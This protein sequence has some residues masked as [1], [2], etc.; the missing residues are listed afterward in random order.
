MA[1][2]LAVVLVTGLGLAYSSDR[3]LRAE[4][5]S[6]EETL[7]GNNAS[8]AQEEVAVREEEPV[9]KAAPEAIEEQVEET[10]D[11]EEESEEI[12]EASAEELADEDA[13]EESDSDDPAD[14]EEETWTVTFYNRDAEVHKTVKVAKGEAIG[15][16]L[17]AVI[18]REDYRAYWA[19]GEIV[20]G[21]QGKEI[22][23][24]G[25][26]INGNFKPSADTVIV[27]DYD[28]ISYSITFL[29]EKD[30]NVLTTKTVDYETSY[31]LNDIPAVPA[32]EGAVGKWAYAGGVFNNSVAVSGDTVVWAV[33]DKN[34]FTVTFEVNGK[35]YETDT[36]FDGD[37]LSLPADPVVE[38]K[39]FKGWFAG[40]KEYKGGETVS[41]DMTLTAEFTDQFHVNFTFQKEDGTEET[42]SQFF[43][44][45]GQTIETMP[46]D[47]FVSGKVFEKWVNVR[48]GEEVTAATVVNENIEARAQFRAVSVYDITV[49]YYYLN[50]GGQEVIFTREMMQAESHELPYTI[51]APATIQTDPNEVSGAPVYYP[52]NPTVTLK[53]SDFSGNKATVRIKFV[54]FTAVYDFVYLLKD[55]D[56]E[57]YTEID[58]TPNV[59]GVLNSYV[60]PAVKSFDYAVLERAE[61]ATIEQASGQE[62]NVYYT[63]RNFTL[64]YETNGG[65][66]VGGA[67]VPYGTEQA[68]SS[69]VPARTGY[70]FAGWYLDEGL[71]QPAGQKVTVNGNTTLYAKWTGNKVNYTIVYMAEKFNDNGTSTTYVYDNSKTATAQVGS[72]VSASNAPALSKARYEADAAKNAESSVEIAADGS[73][74]LYVYYKLKS[75]TIEFNLNNNSSSTTMK[76]GGTTYKG[77]SSTRYTITVKLGQSLNGLWP[78]TDNATFSRSGYSFAGWRTG[79]NSGTTYVTKQIIATEELLPTGS[80]SSR[81]FYANWSNKT[82]AY[83]INYYL[84]NADDNGYTLSAEYSQTLNAQN[85]ASFSAKEISGYNHVESKDEHKG[86]TF[87]FYY[88]RY[89][90]AIEYY[91]GSTE[92]KTISGVKFDAHITGS[93]YN[94]TPSAAQCG[95]DSDYRFDGWYSDSGLNSK[96]TFDTM[97]AS[98][99][100]LYAKWTAPAYTVSFVDGDD[101]SAKLAD[102]QTVEKYKKAEKPANPTKAGYSF[103]GWYKT[104]GGDELFDWNTQITGDT[105]V[106]AHW[107]RKNL[108]YTVHYVN[109]EGV[110]VA[111]DKEVTNPNFTVGQDVTEMAI[112]VAGFRP[113]ESSKILTLA[114]DGNEITFVYSAKADKT[115]YTVR[116]IIDPAEYSG[117]IKVAEDKVV[118]EVSGDTSS[119]IEMAAAVDYSALYAAHPELEGLEFHPDQVEKTLVLTPDAERNVLTFKYSSFKHAD[120]TIHYV[121]MAGKSISGDHK[122]MMKVGKTFTLSSTPIEG[123]ELNKAVVG[124]AYGGSEAASEYKITEAAADS[125]L[126]FTLFYQKKATITVAS[127][128][129]QYDGEALT[130]AE[131]L[132]HQ[133]KAEGLMDGHTLSAV[134]FTYANNDVEGGRLNAGIATVTPKDASISGAADNYYI[135][136]YISGTLE[137]TKINV[138]IRVEPDRWTGASYTGNVY[139][140]GF[141][142]PSKDVDD[143]VIIS[144]EGYEAEYLDDIWNAVKAK[145]TYDA[146]AAGLGYYGLAEKDA[147]DYTWNLTLTAADLPQNDNYS[148]SAHVRQGR[149]QILAKEVSVSTEG[150]TKGY[151]GTALTNPAGSISGL[152]QADEGKVTVTGTGSQTEVGESSNTYSIAWGDVN[153]KNYVIANESLGTLKVTEGSIILTASSASKTYDGKALTSSEVTASGLPEGYTV[154]ASASGSQTDAGTG[155]NKVGEAFKVKDA[156]GKDKTA[157]FTVSKRI[158]GTLTVNKAA[159]T[160]TT[161]SASKAYDGEALTNAE[162]KIEGLV[163]GETA[164]VTATGSQ[165]EIGS[166]SNTCSIEWG[167]AKADNYEV[168]QNLG[169]L[170]VTESSIQVILTASSAS[171]TYDG[172]ALT[173]SEVTASG[174]PEGFTVEAS[175]SGS[176]T[177]A[178]TSANVVSDGF[179]IRNAKGEDKTDNFKKVEKVAGTLTVNKAPLTVATGSGSK[180]YDGKA[181]KVAEAE[182]T[183]LVNGETATAAATGSRTEVG[184]GSNT[185]SIAWGTAKAGNY[186]VTENLGTLTVTANDSPVTLT[187]ASA[188][189]TY[190]GKALTDASVTA[191]GLPEGF[192]ADAKAA[193]SQ[194]N[195]G[196][197]ANVVKSGYAIKNAA[198]ENK[199]ANFTNIITAN[200]TLTVSKATLTVTTGS[201]N[202]AYDGRALTEASASIDGLVNNE[203]AK[204]TAKGSQTEVGSSDNGYEITW[205]FGTNKDNY[206]IKENLGTLTVTENSSEIVLTAASASKKYD[207]QALTDSKVKV[208]G[209]PSGFTAEAAAEGS[210]TNAGTGANKVAEGYAIKNRAG[211]DKTAN[212]T[213]IR[214][215]DGTLTVEQRA[216]TLTSASAEKE[217]DGTALTKNEVKVG[218]DGFI[219]GE[220]AEYSVSGSQTEAGNSKNTFTYTLNE[221]TIGDNYSISKAEGTLTVKASTKKVTVTV[222]ENSGNEKYD[223]T[224]KTVSGYEASISEP[225]YKESEFVFSGNA[226]VSGK[227][228]GSYAMELKA[229]DFVNISKNFS[230][231]EFV[232]AD[233]ELVIGKRAVTLTSGTAEKEYDGSAL[234]NGEVTV[235]GDGF[236]AGEGAA[237]QVT[238]S[239]KTVGSSENTFTYT[240]KSGTSAS[241]YDINTVFGMLTVKSRDAKYNATVTAASGEALYDGKEHSVSGF[242]GDGKVTVDGHE[243]TLSGLE[244]SGSGVDAGTYPVNITGTPVVTDEEGNDVTDQFSISMV[245]GSLEITK[246]SVVM[247]SASDEHAY[248]GKAL[249]NDKIEVS[250]DGFAKGE[251]ASYTVTGSQTTVGMS[252]NEFT[253]TLNEGTKAGNYDIEVVFGTLNVFN[254]DAK[255]L[256]TLTP[257]SDSVAY[258]GQQHEVRGFVS[259]T[260]VIDGET[261]RVSGLD[262]AATGTEVGV[263][264][265]S[266]TGTAVVRDSDGNDV[267]EQFA[268]SCGSGSLTITETSVADSTPGT[269]GGITP[270]SPAGGDDNGNGGVTNIVDSIP[271]AA[272]PAGYWAILNLI[273]MIAS[274]LSGAYMII[275]RFRDR[276]EE[277]MSRKNKMAAA[278]AVLLAIVSA[279]VYFITEDMSNTMTLF[280]KY[281]LLMAVMTVGSAASVIEGRKSDSK[282]A[283]AQA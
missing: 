102:D 107:T 6:S 5:I 226:S 251:G 148:V 253:Y 151:D 143:Y 140:A 33:Y 120:I 1:L 185:C 20:Q 63:R 194:T 187:A 169:T 116:Y 25:D 144:H 57:G 53:E 170:T 263:Y 180:A 76:I 30:G 207:G 61:G 278:A 214:T 266:I 139:K 270:A 32:K 81:T 227:D 152:V 105:T 179:V 132:D 38:A 22:R 42:I 133:V 268:V 17:P 202:K 188:S 277:E 98:N 122:E 12:E 97:P 54:K 281:T 24:T 192:T 201:A 18:A 165:T 164:S 197:S 28:K 72:T 50:D 69:M 62:L 8:E 272:A 215:V 129:K 211:E 168:T 216:V 184:T 252:D 48:T 14:A 128:S 84:Q 119:V 104:A 175:A 172:K 103:D 46:Q 36:Y 223:G 45:A 114:E 43:R 118:E 127:A 108:S 9:E 166:S 44:T 115:S 232:I 250:G 198:G 283:E 233:G 228:A 52:E 41:S 75:Y 212:F 92:L 191:S 86:N 279:V 242:A 79:S 171:K 138:T 23:V 200:G 254:R 58:R 225:L 59:Q 231:V 95:V 229:E 7:N 19:V 181:L 66:Y 35:T 37:K 159:A 106:Y 274:V 163:N 241:N 141:T 96:Y 240:L 246:R 213:N 271:V 39:E 186:S 125:G 219:D 80:S 173:S 255:Y 88:D 238:G 89:T 153:E 239:Q 112:S 90:Y 259:T 77:N 260:A 145:A 49:E 161:G 203:Q 158:D 245:P 248:N 178:G 31:C 267:T 220:G 146:S 47:P 126:E 94:W 205:I 261:Y 249:T 182:I 117:S 221:G 208:E 55:A 124:K 156:E 160:V 273:M 40:G 16:D 110:S 82:T 70:T 265:V 157:C 137:V 155:V 3:I 167:T 258:D 21:G 276:D 244:A 113:I 243:Y 230:N 177:D 68:V 149:L 13:A 224:T 123:W 209:L 256:L 190:D 4:E 234:T 93:K 11:L 131:D 26:R 87:S 101:A 269:A 85:N 264:P 206:E 29:D 10:A 210:R 280:D 176:Q 56:G 218:G 222:K 150:A 71:T 154:E 236:A 195:A 27:P 235:S 65:S 109:E 189:K 217:Y 2:I 196:T 247:T 262:A 142:N 100:V 257:N 130:L 275:R 193:G 60:T 51:T 135:I 83:T 111:S 121:D 74:V 147:G 199:T 15:N 73:S 91:C 237:Y 78:T 64:S 174:L 136:R 134:S 282:E 183:G 204:I 67:T 162:A 34:V 99:L